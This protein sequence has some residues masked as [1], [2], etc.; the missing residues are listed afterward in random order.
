MGPPFFRHS[1]ERAEPEL[2]A[3]T[4]ICPEDNRVHACGTFVF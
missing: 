4:P 2:L 3:G 1:A